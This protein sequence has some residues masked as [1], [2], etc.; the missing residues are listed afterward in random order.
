MNS[1]KRILLTGGA[2]FIGSNL[3]RKLLANNQYQII[4]LDNFDDFYSRKQ[5]EISIQSFLSNK[6]YSFFEGD[7]RS[8]GDL[9]RVGE[10]DV[11]LH[12]AAKAGVR[13]SIKNPSLYQDVNVSGTQNL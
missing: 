5:K 3:T 4:S 11:I 2:G 9:S 13:P 1:T 10:I 7:I 12:L 8:Q 6:N